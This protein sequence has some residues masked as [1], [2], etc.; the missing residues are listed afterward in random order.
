MTQQQCAVTLVIVLPFGHVDSGDDLGGGFGASASANEPG[1][2]F[3]SNRRSVSRFKLRAPNCMVDFFIIMFVCTPL[4]VR[5]GCSDAVTPTS[6]LRRARNKPHR[7]YAIR[8]M[9]P[10]VANCQ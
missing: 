5:L 3:T 2:C 9:Q 6:V 1:I 4:L 8:G 10:I 7:A